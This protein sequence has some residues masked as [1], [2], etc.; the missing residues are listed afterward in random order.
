M[1]LIY[2]PELAE[3]RTGRNSVTLQI[4]GKAGCYQFLLGITVVPREIQ[5]IMKNLGRGGK[6]VNKV[7][8]GLC[9]N[10]EYNC[11]R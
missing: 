11:H 3:V 1:V 7:H 8:Y 10:G 6:G 2:K 5:D 9:E 4:E